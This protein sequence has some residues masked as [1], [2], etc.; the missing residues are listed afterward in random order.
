MI[1]FCDGPVKMKIVWEDK[2]MTRKEQIKNVVFDI[3]GV[4]ADFRFKEVLEEKG[5][6]GPMIKRVLKAS[7]MNPYWGMFERGKRAT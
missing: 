3:G 4:L 1:R 5:L 6:D 7:V 2:R